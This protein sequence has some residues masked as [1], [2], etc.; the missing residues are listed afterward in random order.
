MM[1]IGLIIGKKTSTGVPGKNV[2]QI[3]GRPAAEY[4]FI[5]AKYAGLDKVNPSSLILSGEMLLRYL[6]WN[7]AAD[8][9]IKGL[10]TTFKQKKV[11]YDFA[12]QLDNSELLKCSEFADAI[13]E[14]M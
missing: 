1:N 5:A 12:R 14:N 7:D 13:I 11:T 2:R 6:G 9:I 10:N 8:K 4:A 3:V